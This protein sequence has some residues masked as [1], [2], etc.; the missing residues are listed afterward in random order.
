MTMLLI[1]N[2]EKLRRFMPN[3]FT[4]VKGETPL[5]DKLAPWL[6]TSEK[7][8]QENFCGEA[9]MNEIVA[10]DDMNVVKS[11]ASQI[12]VCEALRYAV[13][14]LDLV[15]TPNGFGI[16]SNQNVAPASKERVERLIESL[17]D[18]RDNAVEL[19]LTSLRQ[20]QSWTDSPQCR[21]F[22]ATLFPN[23]DLVSLCGVTKHRW[24]KYVELRSMVI[25]IENS[26][27]DE[28][29]SH[30]FMQIL[31][32]QAVA[33]NADTNLSWIVNRLKPL[34]VDFI[35]DKP[36]AQQKIV[37]IVNFIRNNPE[38]FPEWHNSDTAKLFSPPKFENKITNK[39]YWF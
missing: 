18:T 39:G 20:M 34:I 38:E 25:G 28:Y 7:W 17:Y 8:L 15:L 19:L 4:T 9:S 16:V 5:F 12:V 30:E 26:L 2:D 11:L 22:M 27:A 10:M 33:T 14:S 13:P 37:D 35:A 23:I 24:E 31:R 36:I 1:T 29:F 32:L 21:W 6:S 3:A